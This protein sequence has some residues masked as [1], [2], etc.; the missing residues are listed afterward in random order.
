[1]TGGDGDEVIPILSSIRLDEFSARNTVKR[2][3]RVPYFFQLTLLDESKQSVQLGRNG[4]FLGH[5][6]KQ[7]HAADE[8]SSSNFKATDTSFRRAMATIQFEL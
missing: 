1:M 2:I 4:I 5:L 8:A 6:E 7:D 3:Q